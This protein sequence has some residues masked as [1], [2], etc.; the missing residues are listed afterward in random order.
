MSLTTIATPTQVLAEVVANEPAGAYRR[1]VLRAPAIAERATPGHFVA[2]AIGTGDG[3]SALLLR[4]AFSLH[5]ANPLDGTIQLVVAPHAPGTRWICERAAGDVIDVVGPA[6]QPFEAPSDGPCV[7]IGGGYG[8]APLQWWAEQLKAAGLGVDL[9]VGAGDRA[10]L[11]GHEAATHVVT[12]DG[13]AG[14]RGRVTD[15]LT[16]L[17]PELTGASLVTA[18]PTH[19]VGEVTPEL[20]S[21]GEGTPE[22]TR[23]G[24]VTVYAC[25]PMG[26]LRAVHELA[27]AHGALTQLA[28][29][30]S[31]ACG[32]GVCMTCVLPVVG[33]DG[34]T[35]MTRSCVDG[36]VFDGRRLRWDALDIRPGRTSSHVPADCL[37]APLPDQSV[38]APSPA[39]GSVV[40]SAARA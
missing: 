3:A 1:L 23:S 21:L 33:S 22:P 40:G 18:E 34:L 13:S 20:T 38:A 24:Q 11:F 4:R 39:S 16:R 32:V 8:A 29:E 17:L 15:V 26:M 2:C 6:G 31:M 10:R 25:G 27:S 19:S 9:V 7:L 30:E 37:G 35:R 36:P 12:E 28:V 14:E 5:R